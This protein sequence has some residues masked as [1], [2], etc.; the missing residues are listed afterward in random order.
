MVSDPKEQNII[1]L[2][3]EH[4]R[5]Q[6][7]QYITWHWSHSHSTTLCFYKPAIQNTCSKNQNQARV[8]STTHG[9][10]AFAQVYSNLT[11]VGKS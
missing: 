2:E 4:F 8:G 3:L 1:D 7:N 5:L 6:P 9:R 10:I 11:R